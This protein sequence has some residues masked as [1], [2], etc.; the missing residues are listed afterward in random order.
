MDDRRYT[1]GRQ[2]CIGSMRSLFI[3]VAEPVFMLSMF[4]KTGFY[5]AVQG[6]NP[7]ALMFLQQ[8]MLGQYALMNGLVTAA[9]PPTI[10]P[11]KMVPHPTLEPV[12]VRKKLPTI[13]RYKQV[14]SSAREET[15]QCS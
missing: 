6:L 7:Q 14:N 9:E 12:Q 5:F 2:T 3:A 1:V 13:F 10:K 15:V 4:A 8:Q 11:P